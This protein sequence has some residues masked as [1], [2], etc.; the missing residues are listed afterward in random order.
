MSKSS[1]KPVLSRKKMKL[2][3]MPVLAYIWTLKME[4][5]LHGVIF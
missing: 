4:E 1:I 5:I 3:L 2:S